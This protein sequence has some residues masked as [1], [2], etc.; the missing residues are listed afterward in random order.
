MQ[1]DTALAAGPDGA[2]HLLIQSLGLSTSVVLYS[3]KDPTGRW[4]TFE[5]VH[6]PEVTASQPAVIATSDG[7]V[8]VV[9]RNATDGLCEAHREAGQWVSTSIPGGNSVVATLAAD[10]EGGLHLVA[11]GLDRI[12]YL[13]HAQGVWDAAVELETNDRFL[14]YNAG[15]AVAARRVHVSYCTAAEEVRYRTRAIDGLSEPP[16][17]LDHKRS[18]SCGSRLIV[19]EAGAVHVIYAEYPSTVGELRAVEISATGEA[20]APVLLSKMS[21]HAAGYG[22]FDLTGAGPIPWIVFA[23][24]T[25]H[26]GWARFTPGGAGLVHAGGDATLRRRWPGRGGSHRPAARGPLVPERS[27]GPSLHP[28]SLIPVRASRPACRTG[29]STT[30]TARKSISEQRSNRSILAQKRVDR[31]VLPGAGGRMLRRP[32]RRHRACEAF[33]E[34]YW[35]EAQGDRVLDVDVVPGSSWTADTDGRT[36]FSKNRSTSNRATATEQ[37]CSCR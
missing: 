29:L 17:I 1:G 35:P 33:K 12:L 16:I 11:T 30:V 26:L 10:M 7:A 25:E 27:V 20:G 2:L 37:H 34:S 8:H 13:H 6:P 21:G 31:C 3:R 4:S 5:R 14:G 15:L 32:P 28:L 23:T 18:D 36:D 9:Y 24:A 19:G 22:G